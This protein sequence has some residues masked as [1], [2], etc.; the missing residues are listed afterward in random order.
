MRSE[1]LTGPENV[2]S[3]VEN[4][5]QQSQ[6]VT[7]DADRRDMFGTREE[8]RNKRN[9]EM[10]MQRQRKTNTQKQIHFKLPEKVVR[11]F[12]LPSR[13]ISTDISWEI[14]HR[15]HEYLIV[16]CLFGCPSAIDSLSHCTQCKIPWNLVRHSMLHLYGGAVT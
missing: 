13:C 12:G 16:P 9:R 14:S 2:K 11:I 5:T 8:T 4:M 1:N 10:Q 7:N 6:N 15:Y 3:T